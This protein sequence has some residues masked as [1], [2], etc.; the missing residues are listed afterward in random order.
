MTAAAKTLPK[1]P[2]GP[3]TPAEAANRLIAVATSQIGY[4]EGKTSSGS[5]NNDTVFG[6]WYGP[7]FN[8]AAW[9]ASFVSWCAAKAAIPAAVIPKHAYTPTGWNWFAARNLDVATPRRGDIMYV[10]GPVSGEKNSRVHHVGIVENVLPGG[11]IQTIEGNTNTTGSASG[12][13]VYRLK[14]KVSSKLRFARPAYEMAV[15][16]RPK[17]APGASPKPGVKLDKNGLPPTGGR[18][19]MDG[20]GHQ[21]LDLAVLQLAARQP[22]LTY[23]TWAQREAACGSFKHPR[24][25]LMKPTEPVTMASFKAAWKRWQQKLGYKGKDADGVPGTESFSRLIEFTGRSRKK[26]SGYKAK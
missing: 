22:N 18:P 16:A 25:G 23:M 24:L 26:S 5:Y 11:Y 9:C 10:Y 21:I 1:L 13:G 14:R 8:Y 6:A 15:I 4:R 2:A 3:Y 20:E 19:L 7:G 12:N 17:P